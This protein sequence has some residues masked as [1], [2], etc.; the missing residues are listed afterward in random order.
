[1]KNKSLI[2]ILKENQNFRKSISFKQSLS[3]S[4]LSNNVINQLDPIIENWIYSNRF[5]PEIKFGEF[6]NILQ[7]SQ[8]YSSSDIV[9]IFWELNNIVEG[10]HYKTE[11]LSV[12]EIEEFLNK[13]KLEIDFCITSLSKTPLVIFNKFS[14]SPFNSNNFLFQSYQDVCFEL[15]TYLINKCPANFRLIEIDKIISKISINNSY[16]F[17]NFYTSKAPYSFDFFKEYMS[18]VSPF[19][20]AKIGLTKKVLVLDCDNTLWG[21]IV[22]EDG[23]DGIK[24]DDFSGIGKVFYEVQQYVVQL[25]NYGVVVCFNSKNNINDVEE[26]FKLKS[27]PIN[28]DKIVLKKINWNNKVSNLIEISNE[29][30][31]GI[32]SLVFVDDSDFEINLVKE[33]LPE[34]ETLQVPKNIYNY[35]TRFRNLM[36]LFTK[37]NFSNEDSIKSKMYIDEIKRKEIKKEFIDI[38]EYLKSLNLKMIISINNQSLIERIAQMTQK[39]NQFNSTTVRLTQNEVEK[40]MSIKNQFVLSLKLEDKFGDFGITGCAFI[41]VSKKEAIVKNILLSCRVLGRTVED[42]FVMEIL[43]F[44]KNMKVNICKFE[45]I[46]SKKNSQV[47]SFFNKIALDPF[48]KSEDNEIYLIELKKYQIT[49][50]KIIE[51][52]YEK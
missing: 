20:S 8:K 28:Y 26:V 29:L 4:V 24:C 49:K 16:N 15:N 39:T 37:L 46:K 17:R 47:Q 50:Q 2:D 35:P 21:G 19:L 27:M 51:I 48:Y 12:S 31:V 40:F 11:N 6:D 5:H 23:F 25:I 42:T 45:F 44:L 41:E 36:N 30:N 32:D 33:N 18:T 9:F 14:T 1:M 3:V 43:K 10:F 7:D 34:V 22:G 38:N 13:I 52:D